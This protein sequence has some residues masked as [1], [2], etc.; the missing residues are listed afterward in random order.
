MKILLKTGSFLGLALT[1]VPSL[2]FF[3]GD[4]ELSH[5]KIYMGVGMVLWF[6]TAPFWINKSSK[7][8]QS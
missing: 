8:E 3:T 5:M 4:L 6:V 7:S 1:I 2:I